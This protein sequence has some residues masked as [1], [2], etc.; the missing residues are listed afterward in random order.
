MTAESSKQVSEILAEARRK[1]AAAQFVE[2]TA[3]EMRAL[4]DAGDP[5]PFGR[6]SPQPKATVTGQGA[7]AEVEEGDQQE[8]QSNDK[9][10]EPSGLG[11]ARPTLYRE[12]AG[13]W[14]P[15]WIAHCRLPE[16]IGLTR[17]TLFQ[18]IVLADHA[19]MGLPKTRRTVEGGTPGSAF[20]IASAD[21]C[22]RTG[23]RERTMRT[24]IHE[25]L[26]RRLLD[27]YQRGRGKPG[28]YDWPEFHIRRGALLDLFALV[29][30]CL[31]QKNGG[32]RGINLQRVPEEGLRIY[33][34]K[35][36]PGEI[37]V[38]FEQ[39]VLWARRGTGAIDLGEVGRVCR[40]E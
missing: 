27:Y 29:G 2:I 3:D 25:L 1:V 40:G 34:F 28:G 23:L 19:S 15:R 6:D 13:D 39:L 20:A 26:E 14:I 7:W 21:L 17:W 24:A 8:G 31:Q 4:E 11:R 9:A 30:P 35:G 16:V 10:T 5:D 33:G 36:K 18:G 12:V 37:T 32:Y 22:G 38:S